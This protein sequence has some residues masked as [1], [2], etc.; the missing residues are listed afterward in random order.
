MDSEQI[1]E[2]FLS[3]ERWGV[4]LDHVEWIVFNAQQDGV[5]L[6]SRSLTAVALA[7]R[8]YNGAP[9]ED[10]A[11]MKAHEGAYSAYKKSSPTDP[12][13]KRS[14][15]DNFTALVCL[16]VLGSVDSSA[17]NND[18][19]FEGI[20]NIYTDYMVNVKLLSTRQ[21]SPLSRWL[22]KNGINQKDLINLLEPWAV[23]NA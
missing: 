5:V 17:D 7:R 21:E 3:R 18:E 6:D 12:A 8:I 14:S 1:W 20:D 10:V 4:L 19:D 2:S 11:I 13:E 15:I 16:R 9:K 23:D 22:K